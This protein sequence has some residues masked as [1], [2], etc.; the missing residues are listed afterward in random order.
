MLVGLLL[1]IAGGGTLCYERSQRCRDLVDTNL[2]FLAAKLR[3]FQDTLN[4]SS[5]AANAL[6]LWTRVKALVQGA[7]A[8]KS[9]AR[10][11]DVELSGG[12]PTQEEAACED[13]TETGRSSQPAFE[14][15]DDV[16]PPSGLDEAPTISEMAQQRIEEHRA[17][18]A[19]AMSRPASKPKDYLVEPRSTNKALVNDGLDDLVPA[20]SAKPFD[21][22]AESLTGGRRKQ[23][24][25]SL[26]GDSLSAIRKAA[27]VAQQGVGL[28]GKQSKY[29]DLD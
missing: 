28:A 14:Q 20:S 13:D 15:H 21:S 19:H 1:M 10:R 24:F 27:V 11:A 9:A 8:A 5:P 4:H 17:R 7:L 12:P 6:A 16:A 26:S 22:D 18:V 29:Q 25:K 3:S 2:P 23:G